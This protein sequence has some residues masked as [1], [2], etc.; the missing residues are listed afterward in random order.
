MRLTNDFAFSGEPSLAISGDDNVHVI[1]QDTRDGNGEIYYKR[2]ETVSST[3]LPTMRNETLVAFPNPTSGATRFQISG[4]LG[5]ARLNLFNSVG[6]FISSIDA[7]G[8]AWIWDGTNEDGVPVPAGVYFAA[9]SQKKMILGRVV[10][11]RP[12]QQ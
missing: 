4:E 10:V 2:G 9:S 6:R 12:R 7:E 3:P 11:A 8:G 5:L 1:W